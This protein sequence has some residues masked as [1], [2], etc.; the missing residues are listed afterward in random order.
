MSTLPRPLLLPWWWLAVLSLYSHGEHF[1][2]SFLPLLLLRSRPAVSLEKFLVW[3]DPSTTPSLD[4][5]LG[6]I[7]LYYLTETFPTSI[8]HYRTS[9]GKN[10]ET[11][12]KK[13]AVAPT[14]TSKPTGY[15]FFPYDLIVTPLEW[16]KTKV[17]LVWGRRHEKG[18]HF[19]ALEVPQDFWN[20]VNDFVEFVK[21]DG[22]FIRSLM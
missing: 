17:N 1:G 14:Y 10:M 13:G 22:T 6:N 20:D 9:Y 16:A 2:P 4:Q 15:S 7:S 18:G 19:A 8:Y 11:Y 12:K 3:S 21:K 5:I